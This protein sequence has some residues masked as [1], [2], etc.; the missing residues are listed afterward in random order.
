M[1]RRQEWLHFWDLVF[2]F[3]FCSLK[4]WYDFWSL[5]QVMGPIGLSRRPQDCQLDVEFVADVWCVSTSMDFRQLSS[6]TNFLP[7]AA[8]WRCIHKLT[9]AD[10]QASR[11]GTGTVST[12]YRKKRCMIFGPWHDDARR[13]TRVSKSWSEEWPFMLEIHLGGPSIC[14][15]VGG[16]IHWE[17]PFLAPSMWQICWGVWISSLKSDFDGSNSCGWNLEILGRPLIVSL[18]EAKNGFISWDQILRSKK[19][20]KVFVILEFAGK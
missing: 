1:R 2:G 14:R 15:R 17:I 18:G 7:Q 19:G 12:C 10:F 20:A 8:P 6:E 13:E 9:H 5:W 16:H 4:V 3:V 11:R